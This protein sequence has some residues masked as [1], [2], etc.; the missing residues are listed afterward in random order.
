MER[1]VE[2]EED[3]EEPPEAKRAKPSKSKSKTQL[4]SKKERKRQQNR[5]AAQRYSPHS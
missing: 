3:G 4:A 1:L 2:L 5:E